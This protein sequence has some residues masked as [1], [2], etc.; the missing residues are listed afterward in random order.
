MDVLFRPGVRIYEST[1][2][3]RGSILV[4]VGTGGGQRMQ[5]VV[6]HEKLSGYSHG[7]V[8]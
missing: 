1:T 5:I 2:T 3:S 7:G 4:C 8:G 6:V